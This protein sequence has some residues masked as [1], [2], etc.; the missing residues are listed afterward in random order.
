[1]TTS[2]QRVVIDKKM[3][4]KN[5]IDEAIKRILSEPY[6]LNDILHASI[7]EPLYDEM[8]RVFGEGDSTTLV[9]S[10]GEQLL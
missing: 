4:R 10:T 5:I 7:L 6:D 2:I 1:M 3:S 9:G 8:E